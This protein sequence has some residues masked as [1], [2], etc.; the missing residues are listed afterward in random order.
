MKKSV[1]RGQSVQAEKGMKSGFGADFHFLL[2][3][4]AKDLHLGVS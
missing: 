1:L 4:L 3:A 2:P